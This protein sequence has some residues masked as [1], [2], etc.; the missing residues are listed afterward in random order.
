MDMYRFSNANVRRCESPS[1]FNH[2]IHDWSAS[3][4]MTAITGEL[5][6]A[7]NIV[8]KLNR[9][10]DGVAGNKVSDDVLRAHLRKEIADV[11][12]YLDL[13]ARHQGFYLADAV[14]EVFNAKSLDIGYPEILPD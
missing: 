3:D 7:A 11:F 2:N 6:E 5:G 4:W 13:F 14:I 9:S 12:V 8:K 1:G 10:R